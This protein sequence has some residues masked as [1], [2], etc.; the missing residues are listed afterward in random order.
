MTAGRL[1]VAATLPEDTLAIAAAGLGLDLSTTPRIGLVKAALALFHGS[2]REDAR[3][4]VL[5]HRS[6]LSAD[7]AQKVIGQIPAELANVGD[8][9]RACAIRVGMGMA[10]GLSRHEA[11]KWA[12][13]I[14]RGRPAGSPNKPK[15]T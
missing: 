12:S 2:S 1:T 4:L 3:K 6:R 10:I 8:A 9:E 11:E 13:A 14:Q 7:G 5:P 15:P